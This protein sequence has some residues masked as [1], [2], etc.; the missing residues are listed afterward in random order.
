MNPHSVDET[1]PGCWDVHVDY[2]IVILYFY[3]ETEKELHLQDIGTHS[4]FGFHESKDDLTKEE[5]K[6]LLQMI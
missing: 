4:D 3:K 1:Y 6:E 5:L 2:D